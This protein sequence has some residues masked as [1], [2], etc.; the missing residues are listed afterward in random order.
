MEKFS[1]YESTKSIRQSRA[2][3]SILAS[4]SLLEEYLDFHTMA[5]F[6]TFDLPNKI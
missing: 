5:N 6:D 2:V 3:S 4:P 1:T